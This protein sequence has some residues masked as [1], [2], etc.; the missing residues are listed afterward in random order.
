MR[1]YIAYQGRTYQIEWYYNDKGQSQALEYADGLSR[2]DRVKLENLLRVMGDIGQIRNKTKF[3][4]EGDQLYAF[5]P[6]PHRFLCFFVKG[7]KIIITNGFVKKQ[8]KLPKSEKDKAIKYKKDY[9]QRTKEET[10]YE[11]D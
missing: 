6:Q 9:Q 10:Y 3:R 11:R 2:S 5:K 7:R 4:S 8:D 1:E